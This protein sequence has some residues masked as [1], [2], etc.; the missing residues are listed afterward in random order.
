VQLIAKKEI[1][2]I[3]A[4]LVHCFAIKKNVVIASPMYS[5]Q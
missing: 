5:S 3:V 2:I 1:L 4:A